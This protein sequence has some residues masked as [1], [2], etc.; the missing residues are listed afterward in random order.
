[1]GL[2]LLSAEATAAV[3]APADATLR[4]VT[5]TE[6]RDGAVVWEASAARS[7]IFEGEQLARLARGAQAVRVVLHSREGLVTVES[8]AATVNLR[9]RDIEFAG[10]VAART[11][12]GV[13]LATDVLRWSAARRVLTSDRAVAIERGGLRMHGTGMEATEDLEAVRL[14]GEVRS[15]ILTTQSAAPRRGPGRVAL[16]LSRP[17]EITSSPGPARSVTQAK[18]KA[19]ARGKALV[20]RA[21]RAAR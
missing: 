12:R 19:K 8:Q 13:R 3:S 10:P 9:T 11:D 14:L 4:G 16:V 7:E 1:M 15:E 5:L 17:S 20:R 6:T 2:L 18:A 21:R